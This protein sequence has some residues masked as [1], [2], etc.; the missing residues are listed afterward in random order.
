MKRVRG[1]DEERDMDVSYDFEV[2]LL[3]GMVELLQ[4][5][6]Q[7]VLIECNGLCRNH[8]VD[9]RGRGVRNR[10]NVGLHVLAEHLDQVPQLD[11]NV[12][13]HP[14][15]RLY[16]NILYTICNRID[17][18]YWGCMYVCIDHSKELVH[19]SIG[20]VEVVHLQVPYDSWQLLIEKGPMLGLVV[21]KLRLQGIVHCEVSYANYVEDEEQFIQRM[22][23]AAL[24]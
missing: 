14:S 4:L 7:F 9:L 17:S 8:C 12:F 11:V 15:N 10:F 2:I 5:L 1:K 19:V 20:R 6:G 3:N 23:F 18:E 22:I 24:V 13:T 21:L 16:L